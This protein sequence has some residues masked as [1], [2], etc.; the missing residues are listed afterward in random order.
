MARAFDSLDGPIILL[1]L[2]KDPIFKH[3]HLIDL[4]GETSLFEIFPFKK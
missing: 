4:R 2:K 1:G 3:L